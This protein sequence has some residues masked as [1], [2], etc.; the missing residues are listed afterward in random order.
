MSTMKHRLQDVQKLLEQGYRIVLF[1][2]GMGE[3]CALAVPEGKT[4]EQ[5]YREWQDYDSPEGLDGEALQADLVF[6]GANR[7]V[8]SG[9]DVEAA[10]RNCASKMLHRKLADDATNEGKPGCQG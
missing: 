10:L 5:A 8:G 4:C 1:T 2:D 9:F 6:G 3:V 7:T